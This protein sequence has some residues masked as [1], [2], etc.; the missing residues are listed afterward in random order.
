MYVDDTTAPDT[1]I[2]VPGVAS[3]Q[4]LNALFSDAPLKRPAGHKIGTIDLRMHCVNII[5]IYIH[6]LPHM[7]GA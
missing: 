2:Y 4:S 3:E 6:S 5:Y 7:C 1:G